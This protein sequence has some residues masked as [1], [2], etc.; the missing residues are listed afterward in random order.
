L[1]GILQYKKGT[2]GKTDADSGP[3]I[4]GV[5]GPA[6]IVGLRVMSLMKE[7]ETAIG[8]RNSIETFGF[9]TGRSEQKK[10]LFGKLPMA[11]VFICWA[12]STETNPGTELTTEKHWRIKFQLYSL[13]ILLP[14]TLFFLRLAGVKFRRNKCVG[15]LI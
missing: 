8:L 6:S 9:G 13:L 15:D 7:N 2:A 11:D 1:P 14:V 12:N 5:G 4:F 10:Y 3:V